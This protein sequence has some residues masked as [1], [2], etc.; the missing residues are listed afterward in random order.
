MPWRL[1]KY[2]IESQ[3]FQ[4]LGIFLTLCQIAF[5]EWAQL[6]FYKMCY[7]RIV[8]LSELLVLLVVKIFL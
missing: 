3:Y 8:G 4:F 2:K 5:L 6:Y 7:C 1:K